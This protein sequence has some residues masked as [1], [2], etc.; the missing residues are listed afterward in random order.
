MMLSLLLAPALLIIDLRPVAAAECSC[1]PLYC[2]NDPDFPKVIQEKKKALRKEGFPDRYIALLDRQGQ[3]PACITNAPDGF[4]IILVYAQGDA[5]VTKEWDEDS[6][7][8]AKEH[9]ATGTLKEYL[10]VNS[11]RVC[12]CCGQPT[13]ND[14]G[15]FDRALNLNRS[16]A[17]SCKFDPSGRQVTC[18]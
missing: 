17:I 13:D 2:L 6:E 8:I 4:S 12:T 5:V 18:R 3:C 15:D 10:I 16:A 11:T 7:R 9:L 14:R 1:G